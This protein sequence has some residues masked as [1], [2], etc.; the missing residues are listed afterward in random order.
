MSGL[1]RETLLDAVEVLRYAAGDWARNPD[2]VPESW[3]LG[4]EWARE[5]RERSARLEALAGLLEALAGPA[6]DL[7][8]DS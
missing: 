2:C 4:R 5:I 6:G 8:G 7:G 1:E 3:E